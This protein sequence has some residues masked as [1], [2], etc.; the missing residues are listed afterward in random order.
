MPSPLKHEDMKNKGKFLRT[1]FDRTFRY[2]R[3]CRN[4]GAYDEGYCCVN[5][6]YVSPNDSCGLYS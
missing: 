4:C 3:I 6:S 2:E 1:N 5:Q